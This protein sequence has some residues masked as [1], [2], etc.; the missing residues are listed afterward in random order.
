VKGLRDRQAHSQRLEELALWCEL[1]RTLRTDLI[2]L[3]SSFLSKDEIRGDFEILIE[4]L[5]QAAH[6]AALQSPPIRLAYEALAWGTY[7]D[8]WYDR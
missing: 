1:A 6:V 7:V 2:G 8:T 3:P 5:R 4:D